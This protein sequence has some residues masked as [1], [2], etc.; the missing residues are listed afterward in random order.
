MNQEIPAK[1]R[2]LAQ[3]RALHLFFNQLA[4]ELT[5]HGLDMRK[6]L[7]PEIDIP[8]S[9]ETVKEFLWRPVMKAQLNKESTTE[10]TT[11]DIDRVFDTITKHLGEKFGLTLQFPSIE[12]IIN[13]SLV[14]G[15][16]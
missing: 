13:D 2:T 11:A 15:A 1:Q 5:A 16:K 12:T 7:K 10:M 4:E 8:W 3:N 14:K 9:G 6:T